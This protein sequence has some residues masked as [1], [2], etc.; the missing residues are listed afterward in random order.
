MEENR[1]KTILLVEDEA[2]IAISEDRML[3]RHGYEVVTAS[4][5]EAAIAAITRYPDISLILMDIDLGPG[6]DGTEAA[7][8]ILAIRNLP[9]VFLSSHTDPEIVEKT[10]GITS[11]GYIVKNSG[12]TVLIASIRMAF[13]LHD[14]RAELDRYFN[15]SLDL[16]CIAN[17][18]GEFIRLNPEWER[19]LGYPIEELTGRSFFD[20]VHPEDQEATMR[21]VSR[22]AAGED[23]TSF[24]NRYCHSDG[25]Y[26]Y[27]EWRS[28]P[29]DSE[30]YAAARDVTDQKQVEASLRGSVKRFEELVRMVPVGV[31]VL[32]L[33]PDRRFQF[34]YVSDGWC[35]IHRVSRECALADIEIVDSQ[36]HPDEQTAFRSLNRKTA[37]D[38][39]PFL[40][41]GR[42]IV[43]DGQL[44]WLRI[45]STPVVSA[46]GDTHWFGVTQDISERKRA[47]EEIQRQ[48]SEKETL[49]TEV[50]HRIKNNMAQV[51][52][53]LMMQAD[54]AKSPDVA[55]ALNDAISRVRSIR[56]IYEKLLAGNRYDE[57]SMKDY[58]ESLIDSVVQVFRARPGVTVE[59]RLADFP[60][61]TGTAIPIGI[62]INELLT[63]AFKYAFAG[64]S[65]GR[66]LIEL[67]R[68]DSRATL[69]VRDDGIGMEGVEA[70]DEVSGFGLTIVRML[71]E[72]LGGALTVTA[73]NG[74]TCRLEFEC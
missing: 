66:I 54:S 55:S 5:G 70:L 16:L 3:R 14:A 28:R 67:E 59:K 60:L 69:A 24:V 57:V 53:I 15:S 73:D 38:R 43:G 44:R 30:I 25:S 19:V 17:T 47:E 65:E 29:V 6:I 64:R 11:Y 33:R 71:A 32:C 21:A 20:F 13:R 52:G 31:Y 48:L 34:E 10:E 74:T 1:A 58:L 51:E 12:E 68:T 41:E 72:Q 63:N 4:S 7:N 8:R 56:S 49:L 40:W 39:T 18:S 62:I 46:N 2:I 27:I 22:L 9:V 35:A 61:G 42:F 37:R 50:H 45:E 36:S 23:V 26:R